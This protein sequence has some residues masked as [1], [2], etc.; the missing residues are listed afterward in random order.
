MKSSRIERKNSTEKVRRERITFFN[1]GNNLGLNGARVY[2]MVEFNGK[3]FIF[4]SRPDKDWVPSDAMLVST[5]VRIHPNESHT[6]CGKEKY[7]PLPE[8]LSPDDIRRRADQV[9]QRLGAKRRAGTT[10]AP[11]LLVE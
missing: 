3:F 7:Y 10:A 6:D 5:V 9:K 4:N 11:T 2:A 8:R 1:K